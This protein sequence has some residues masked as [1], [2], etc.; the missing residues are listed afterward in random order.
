M[1][2]RDLER[3]PLDP[4]GQ[5][6]LRV[7]ELRREMLQLDLDPRDVGLGLADRVLRGQPIGEHLPVPLQLEAAGLQLQGL[8][9]PRRGQVVAG[10]LQVQLGL[11]ALVPLESDL[12]LQPGRLAPGVL[13]VEQDDRLARAGLGARRLE[14]AGD[15]GRDRRGE[16]LLEPGHD[17][18]RGVERGAD[19]AALDS[20]R[21]DLVAPDRRV[22]PG[23]HHHPE[24][25]RR[26]GQPRRRDQPPDPEPPPQGR[27]DGSVH[28]RPRAS[29]RRGRATDVPGER[30]PRDGTLRAGGEAGTVRFRTVGV[31]K[32]TG[33]SG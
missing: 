10:A 26:H 11:P 14:N 5:V 24:N 22:Q 2:D 13:V 28:G 31:R 15:A 6:L 17:E 1:E 33:P 3:E 23:G 4:G 20:C 25:H 30:S 9:L 21:A 19:V 7:L 12:L 29:S 32:R 8:D 16:N 18:T 27:V